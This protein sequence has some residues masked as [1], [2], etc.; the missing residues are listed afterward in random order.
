MVN[1]YKK[2][3]GFCEA[4]EVKQIEDIESFRG[5]VMR[6][7]GF[8]KKTANKWIKNFEETGYIEVKKKEGTADSWTVHT[9]QRGT[10]VE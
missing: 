9:K 3:N 4:E 10:G 8:S 1:Y 6:F 2:F 7:Y 5:K